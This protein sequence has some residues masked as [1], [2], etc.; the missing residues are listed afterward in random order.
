MGTNGGK[1]SRMAGLS[2]E[3]EMVNPL[4][5]IASLDGVR[6]SG[7]LLALVRTSKGS[8]LWSSV[9]LLIGNETFDV[10]RR[11][12]TLPFLGDAG[13]GVLMALV[14]ISIGFALSS[15]AGM[16]EVIIV[17]VTTGSAGAAFKLMGIV[18]RKSSIVAVDPS[19]MQSVVEDTEDCRS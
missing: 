2:T 14:R 17:G 3:S 10:L 9:G 19:M 13:R 16:D 15:L 4:V 6:G 7:V 5:G 11:V 18:G 12:A 1:D 8:A